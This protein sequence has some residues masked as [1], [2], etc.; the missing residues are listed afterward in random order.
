MKEGWTDVGTESDK[1]FT[2]TANTY[3]FLEHCHFQWGS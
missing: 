1:S 3:I 2:F